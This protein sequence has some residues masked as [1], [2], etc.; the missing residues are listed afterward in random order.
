MST[1]LAH[2]TEPHLTAARSQAALG[3]ELRCTAD[4]MLAQGAIAAAAGTPR[5][6]WRRTPCAPWTRTQ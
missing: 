4:G 3:D 6:G 1:P 2:N 5:D